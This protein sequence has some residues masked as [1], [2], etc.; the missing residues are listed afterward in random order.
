MHLASL[1][2]MAVAQP[3]Y[4]VLRQNGD[5][6]VAHRASLLDLLLF[7]AVISLA[8]PALV[9][10]AVRAVSVVSAGAARA[11]HVALVATL[12]GALASQILGSRP[13]IDL[14]PH[15][16]MSVAA[17][18]L[19]A[20]F[21]THSASARSF[22]SLVSAGIPLFAA[23]FLLHPDMAPFV[24]PLDRTR[25]SAGP[26]PARA[27]PVVMVVF[28]QLPLSSL[29]RPDGA[30]DA[31]RYP[32]FAA[33][34]AGATW[35]RNAS[36]NGELTGWA[37]PSLMTGNL[38]RPSRLPTAQYHPQNLFTVLGGGYRLEVI[39]PITKLCPERL[40][41]DETGPRL[42][43]LVS[44]TL[45]AAVVSLHIILPP[46]LRMHLPPLTNDWRNFAQ[47]VDNWQ[48]RWVRARDTD[49]REPVARFFASI[50]G[51]DAQPTLYFLH[52]LLPH[53][54]YIYLRSGQ[55]FT[56]ETRLPGMLPGERWTQDEWPVIQVY[57]RHL[58]QVEFVDALLARLLA[59]LKEQ[60][61][62][63]RSLIIVTADHGVSFRPGRPW[64]GL[65]EM[66]LPDIMAVPLFIKAPGQQS[67][68][69]DD[70]NMQAIDVLPTVADMVGVRLRSAVDGASA[71]GTA[72]TGT[73]KIIRHS[74]ATREW[75]IETA[76]LAAGRTEAIA[77][78]WR[79]FGA[80][81]TSPVPPGMS[82]DLL[83]RPAPAAGAV[84]AAPVQVLLE[85]PQRF[86]HVDL[87]A[88]VLPLHLAGRVLD[89]EGRP[90]AATLAV[91][92]NGT[93]RAVTR[94]LEGLHA[95]YPGTFGAF[96]E[97][98]T[99]RAGRND[100]QVFVVSND[101]GELQL[102][103]S[104]GDRPETLDLASNAAADFWSVGQAGLHARVKAPASIRWT[105]GDASFVVPLDVDPRPKSLRVGLV[106]P[107]PAGG[108]VRIL[109]NDCTL[110]DGPVE[111]SPWYRT[112]ALHACPGVRS[113]KE[114]H[115][116]IHSG[117]VPG[118]RGRPR[119]VAL[120]VLNLFQGEWPP[121]TA[122][123]GDLRAAVRVVGGVTETVERGQPLALEIQNRGTLA[124]AEAGGGASDPR[125]NVTLELRWRRLPSGPSD[126]S[127]RLR[128]P[129]VLH[130]ADQIRVDVPVVPPS[131]VDGSGPWEVTFVPVT[132][133][134]SEVVAEAPCTVL[135][136]PA[137]TDR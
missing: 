9:A 44:M 19:S 12:V 105:D 34:A 66:T 42:Q 85:Q 62:Y 113:A 26:V 82:R 38:P 68:R 54:P 134:G 46:D 98:G 49:R 41:K 99:L 109:V 120:E 52:A 16:S 55:Q 125:G 13:G 96:L 6:F 21:Y 101:G 57:Q 39:E 87:S 130:P 135:V 119:G 73:R 7:V 108:P 78:R 128:L 32:G 89:A 80:T 5:F 45:D 40:C 58:L 79:L 1:W 137:S 76:D 103:S 37:L 90:R 121:P 133:G 104:S 10:L 56:P 95:T 3:V 61:L 31:Q 132:I 22:V 36:A 67:G 129:R 91:A 122:R 107:P 74:G 43:R 88:P 94:T 35:F 106:G 110:Y 100:L 81:G 29:M 11:L 83:G 112:F 30:I 117:T 69:I 17:G 136:V 123:P 2:S 63:D 53:E 77:R 86:R 65:D 15:V 75:Q 93:I 118:E 70:R 28:D 50:E 72:S 127:Q 8:L 131:T 60:G 51:S 116:V 59:R 33:L 18:V 20:W 114:A 4:D 84:T 92:V 111:S 124:W 24:R 64:K 14:L 23:L 25:G 115:V 102:A 126:R 71:L 97:A 47:A 48:W 27:P